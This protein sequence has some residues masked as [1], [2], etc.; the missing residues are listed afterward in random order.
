MGINDLNN[1]SAAVSDDINEGQRKLA[2]AMGI[3][4][5]EAARRFASGQVRTKGRV[6]MTG[7]A[8]TWGGNDPD[9][10]SDIARARQDKSDALMVKHG[11]PV[12]ATVVE[13][14]S[15]VNDYGV[16]RFNTEGDQLAAQP[17]IEHALQPAIDAIVAEQRRSVVV[18]VRNIE[19][20]YDDGLR[21]RVPGEKGWLGAKGLP[22][23][24]RALGSLCEYNPEY[25]RHI[26]SGLMAD[27][28][29]DVGAFKFEEKIELFNR[30]QRR[31]LNKQFN[32]GA[33]L[34]RL[35]ARQIN[36]E[37]QLFVVTGKD[38]ASDKLDGAV[39]ARLLQE[40][41]RGSQLRGES[42]YDPNTGTLKF[43]AWAMPD[44][45]T[46][47][48]AGDVFKTGIS[49]STNDM[50][51]GGFK[52]W[53]NVIRNLCLNLLI[54]QHGKAKLASFTHR[55]DVNK[56]RRGLQSGI[57]RGTEVVDDFRDLWGTLRD[58]KVEQYDEEG[59]A[60]SMQD[61]L[62]DL[63]KEVKIPGVKRDAMVEALLTGFEAEP[64]ETYADL[65]NAVSRAHLLADI[66]AFAVA[67]E[68]GR[69]LPILAK[70]AKAQG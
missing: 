32:R 6:T 41:F 7:K 19:L 51:G 70:R 45:I 11:F 56:V 15:R 49:G 33:H 65:M 35:W 31:L 44:T 9:A 36:G 30:H 1:Y 40:A 38:H 14:Y 8:G 67:Q 42:S 29:E 53:S 23:T 61:V 26:K 2:A 37:W 68:S 27:P 18:D 28:A 58:V 24:S 39:F 52:L 54:L 63:A 21:I 25:F 43:S 20:N 12:K 59:T 10:K 22:V 17:L 69:L 50:N 48:S 57:A 46:D 13:K 3:T 55:A 34:K 16:E 66:D 64:G 4:P 5:E 60:L 47:L 62:R